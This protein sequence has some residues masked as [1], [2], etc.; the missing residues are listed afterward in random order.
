MVR[1]TNNQYLLREEITDN[2]I[3]IKINRSYRRGMSPEELYDITRGCWKRRIESVD[4]AEFA[5]AVYEGEVVEALAVYKG[6]VVEVYRIFAWYSALDEIRK[7]VPFDPNID[8]GRIIFKGEVAVETIRKKYIGRNVSKLFKHGEA[9]P[10][11]TFY[12]G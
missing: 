9:S 2:I 7:T 5:L 8:H 6:E 12:T 4:R 1:A 3:I 10:V 11:K